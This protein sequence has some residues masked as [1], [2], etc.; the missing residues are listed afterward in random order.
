MSID[1]FMHIFMYLLEKSIDNHKAE[2]RKIA[3]QLDEANTDRPLKEFV[4]R[5]ILKEL[6]TI[7][8]EYLEYELCLNDKTNDSEEQIPFSAFKNVQVTNVYLPDEIDDAVKKIVTDTRQNAVWTNPDLL[9]EIHFNGERVYQTIELKSTKKDAIPGSSV[10]QVNPEEWV[11][12]VRHTATSIGV[13]TGQY[14][15]TVDSKV[16]FPDRSPRPHV[17]FLELKKWNDRNRKNADRVLSYIKDD[18]DDY[19]YELLNDWQG[20]LSNRWV[21]MIFDVGPERSRE[22]W[23]NNNMRKFVMDFLKR[24]DNLNEEEKQRLKERIA[25]KIQ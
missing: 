22:P 25:E 18:M 15:H 24:Y 2:L 1:C 17:S 4:K 13:A 19:K 12:F 3:F 14:I 5:I 21:N 8:E 9:L 10:Q 23:F 6:R 20:V 11:I 16:Q 7:P